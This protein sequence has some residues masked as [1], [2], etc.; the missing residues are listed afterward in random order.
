M[1][2][3]NKFYWNSKKN[4]IIS[5]KIHIFCELLQFTHI[6][7][8]L[9]KKNISHLWIILQT[10]HLFYKKFD[11]N[12]NYGMPPNRFSVQNYMENYTIL[13]H[14]R[15]TSKNWKDNIKKEEFWKFKTGIDHGSCQI[16]K[17]WGKLLFNWSTQKLDIME[18]VYNIYFPLSKIIT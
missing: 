12:S 11:K 8:M 5:T 9:F 16:E 3:Y 1:L 2:F 10:I 15:K 18:K 4:Y 13:N 14:V 6:L 7:W 17:D